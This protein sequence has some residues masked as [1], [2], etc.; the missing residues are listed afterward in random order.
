MKITEMQLICALVCT[1]VQCT[2]AMHALHA[3]IE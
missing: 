3:C 2:S 1:H